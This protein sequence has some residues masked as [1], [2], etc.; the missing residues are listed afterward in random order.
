MELIAE[1]SEDERSEL[2]DRLDGALCVP[3]EWDR[4]WRDE[5][6]RRVAQVEHGETR[7]LTEEEFFADDER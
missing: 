1:L 4:A 2:R 5:L 6:V 7:L 3:E